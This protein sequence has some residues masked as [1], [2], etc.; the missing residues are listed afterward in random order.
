MVQVLDDVGTAAGATQRE[1]GAR[2]VVV[3]TEGGVA[4][5]D[6]AP[7]RVQ[8]GL[9]QFPE[10][11][12]QSGELVAGDVEGLP[13]KHAGLGIFGGQPLLERFI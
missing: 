2:P 12:L 1:V 10:L 7:P 8:E 5:E 9:G 11:R 4:V 3:E 13:V 6:A